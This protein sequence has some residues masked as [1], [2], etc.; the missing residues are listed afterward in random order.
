MALWRMWSD[1]SLLLLVEKKL[2][3][4]PRDETNLILHGNS[5]IKLKDLHRKHFS[6]ILLHPWDVNW[7]CL[8][9]VCVPVCLETNPWCNYYSCAAEPCANS[10]GREARRQAVLK[11]SQWILL[12]S[13][14]VQTA[15]LGKVAFISRGPRGVSPMQQ[16][17][18][19]GNT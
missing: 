8:E 15:L 1:D 19:S 5:T 11:A 16:N 12:P 18:A 13:T 2:S 10:A 6:G 17:V 7:H 4:P 9:T 3:S 14:L